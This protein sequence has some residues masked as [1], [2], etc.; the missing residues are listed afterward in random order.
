MRVLV[1]GGTVFLS[2][3]LAQEYLDRGHDVTCLAR[4][5]DARVP[6]GARAVSADRATGAGAYDDVRAQWDAVVDVASDPRFV[7]DALRVLGARAGHWT[8]VSSCS[9]YADQDRP[10]ADESRA[11]LEPLGDFETSSPEN[12]GA[13]KSASEA[14]CREELVDRLLVV[15]PGLIVGPG[16]PS[17]R[18]GY[19]P[20]RFVRSADDVLVPEA[21]GLWA[22]MIDVAD[23]ARWMASCAETRVTGTMNAVGEPRPLREVI[24]AA[25]RVTGRT[26]RVVVVDD[27]WL[28]EHDVAPWAG[29]RSLPLWIPRGR[30]FDGFTRRRGALARRHGL[31][32][33]PLETTLD[34]VL[35]FERAA[36][37]DR[38]RHAGLD[39][40]EEARLLERWSAERRGPETT[41]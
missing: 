34:R 22:Q 23:L 12:Y 27:Q 26:R 25:Q 36:G 6:E 20:A 29:A 5:A 28:L 15:R 31:S 9:V 37:I 2:R 32:S 39:P 19:W 38:E 1:L 30:G 16:D 3:A 10:D 41:G 13:S 11:V 7:R 24:D 33:S 35:D 4:H 21:K 14:R 40:R 18:G 8:Y 17:D